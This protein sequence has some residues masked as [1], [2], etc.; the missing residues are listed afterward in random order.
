MNIQTRFIQKAI[1]DKNFITFIYEGKKHAN[2]K[3]LRWEEDDKNKTLITQNGHFLLK[4]IAKLEI[5]T[6]KF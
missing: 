3:P 6:T 2:E 4:N 1:E 5:L